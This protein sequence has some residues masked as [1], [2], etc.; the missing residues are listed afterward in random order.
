MKVSIAMQLNITNYIKLTKPKILLLVILTGITA[1]VVEKSLL[2]DPLKFL[3]VVFALA[4]TGGC[5]NALNQYF[6]REIDSQF[7]R[8]RNKRP[9]P[10]KKISPEQALIFALALGVLA[11]TILVVFFNLFS[12][13]L[14]LFTILYYSL[15]Y[16]LWLK[17]RTHQNIV[18]GGAAGAMGPV[19]AW[20][21]A[22]GTLELTPTILF[23]IIF[24]WTPPHFW[25]LALCLKEDYQKVKI[26]MLP[27]VKGDKETLRQI[28][29]YTLVL[30]GISLALLLVKAGL[31]Y[32]VAALILGLL[33]LWKAVVAWRRPSV[34][35]ARGLFGYSILYLF[36]LFVIIMI[37]VF[38]HKSL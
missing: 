12:A 33:Y 37:D 14:S 13:I 16:T 2:S 5:A 22:S 21:A 7:E 24:F 20:A 36:I 35:Y 10:L 11:V 29:I 32:L 3:L 26:P 9:L 17:P 25:A 8:T 1:L 15:F 19:I 6:E 28:L 27:V 23:L 30:F 34:K 31:L 38:W 4:L 18:I